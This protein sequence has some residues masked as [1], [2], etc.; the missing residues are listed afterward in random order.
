M[1]FATIAAFVLAASSEWLTLLWHRA[2]ERRYV[3]RVVA[4]SII[5]ETVS[6]IPIWY[7]IVYTSWEVAAA[8]I[9]GSGLG[10]ALGLT[11][12]HPK[13]DSSPPEQES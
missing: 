2:R 3:T 11:L 10:A 4:V 7:A 13:T 1:V 6:W 9:V 12:L 5:L 8:S